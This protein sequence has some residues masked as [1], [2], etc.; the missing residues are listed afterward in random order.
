M[1]LTLVVEDGS[2]KT[3]S[4]S[5]ATAANG[6][7]YHDKHLYAG[8]WT[9][10]TTATKEAALAMAT[11]L[12][13]QHVDWAGRQ[14]SQDQALAWPRFGVRDRG[15]FAISG[16]TIPQELIEATAE[17]ARLLIA[18]DRTAEADTKG[19]KS[20]AIDGLD[21]EVDK[22]DRARVIPSVVARMIEPL[23]RVRGGTLRLKRA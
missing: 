6:D 17:L 20:V 18:A 23:G 8:A 7:A 15:G 3:D 10:A 16:G 12:L 11:R 21:M 22:D 2:G 14:A 1:A 19:F 4:N 5:Y 13:D 9:G